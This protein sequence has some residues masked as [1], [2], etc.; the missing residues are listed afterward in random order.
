MVKDLL[1]PDY[2]FESSWEDVIKWEGYTPFVDTGE[3]IAGKIPRQNF[4]HRS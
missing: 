3:Y 4:F 2:I 1:T